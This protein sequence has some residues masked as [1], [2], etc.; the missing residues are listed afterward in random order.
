[1]PILHGQVCEPWPSTSSEQ[2]LT[3][4]TA[5]RSP[6]VVIL[7]EDEHHVN[8][9]CLEYLECTRK[10]FS[11]ISNSSVV[12]ICHF[13]NQPDYNRVAKFLTGQTYACELGFV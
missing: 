4:L 8:F 9:D 5:I 2:L 12:S 10:Q 7:V 6:Y 3:A 1:M 11:E 13:L